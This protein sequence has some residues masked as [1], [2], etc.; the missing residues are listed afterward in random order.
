MN[1]EDCDNDG[2]VLVSVITLYFFL[3]RFENF[4][5]RLGKIEAFL[6]RSLDTSEANSSESPAT[7]SE[8][9]DNSGS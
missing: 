8:L 9:S 3:R 2:N 5:E 7:N 1:T 6:S 4:Q